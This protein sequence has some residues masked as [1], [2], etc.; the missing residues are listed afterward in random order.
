MGRLRMLIADDHGF[1]GDG[2]RLPLDTTDDTEVAG[3]TSIGEE[4]IALS[5]TGSIPARRRCATT[6]GWSLKDGG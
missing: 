1:S 3:E 5:P 4:V 2:V 6:P